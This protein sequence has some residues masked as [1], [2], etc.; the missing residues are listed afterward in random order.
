MWAT[1]VIFIKLPIANNLLLVENSSNLV[2]LATSTTFE[3]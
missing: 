2:T 3:G 1:S